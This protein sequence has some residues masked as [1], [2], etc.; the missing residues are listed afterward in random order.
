MTYSCT[1]PECGWKGEYPLYGICGCPVPFCR[2]C[3]SDVEE[4]DTFTGDP[5]QLKKLAGE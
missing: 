1:N 4:I 5:K 2:E 3:D